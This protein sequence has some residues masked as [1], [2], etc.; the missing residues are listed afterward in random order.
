MDAMSEISV[1][2]PVNNSEKYVSEAIESVLAQSF[3]DFE[4]IIV[5]DG[6]TDN[7][8]SII[9][10]FSDE[11]IRL[12]QNKHDFIGS[13]NIGIYNANGKYIA[14][15]D[16]DDIMHIDRLK[17]QQ[18][19]MQE[20]LDVT[21]CGTWAN[22]FG[23]GSQTNNLCGSVSGLVEKPILKLIQDNFLF[24]PTTMLRADFLRKK[25]L[26]YENYSYAEDYK[27][28]SEIAK[29]GGQFYVENQPLLY[30][31]IS[32][33][34]VSNKYR[35]EQ[36]KTTELIIKEIIEYL[37]GQNEREYPELSAMYNNLCNL[38]EK[39]L[40]TKYEIS[41]LFRNLFSKNEKKL[42]L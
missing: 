22:T 36:K 28:W 31:R 32:D 24:H 33:S 16:A 9:Q 17:I 5:D 42:N 2:M 27:L 8:Y 14:R 13:L 35:D 12:I 15:M 37:I 20:Y 6:S 26:K 10:S 39:Q 19:V 7:T 21:V 38:Q 25:S 29:S 11:R 1:V 30:Y 3:D 34:Q 18:A 23:T 41:A 4:F 40:F